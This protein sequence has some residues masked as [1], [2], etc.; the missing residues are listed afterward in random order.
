MTKR[1]LL[2]MDDLTRADVE[3]ILDTAES[4]LPVLHKEVAS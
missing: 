4:F 1:D 2:S 3:F